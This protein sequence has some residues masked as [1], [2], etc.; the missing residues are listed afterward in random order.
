MM[1]YKA[2]DGKARAARSCLLGLV[3]IQQFPGLT[4][5]PLKLDDWVYPTNVVSIIVTTLA[6]HSLNWSFASS[7]SFASAIVYL[8]HHD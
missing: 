7:V 4:F 1:W 6:I 5:T 3:T 8:D 2:K